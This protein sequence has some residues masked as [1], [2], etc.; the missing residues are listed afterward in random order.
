MN[1]TIEEVFPHPIEKVWAAISEPEHLAAWL[2][3]GTFSA[4]TGAHYTFDCGDGDDH[5]TKIIF[6]KV[7]D[8]QAPHRL[9]YTWQGENSGA[10][11]TVTW[12]L[13]AVEGGTLVKMV[14]EGFES[15][16]DVAATRHRAHNDGW[17]Q[18]LWTLRS[19][20]NNMI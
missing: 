18:C 1:I 11:T 13:K 16:G 12:T 9:Q 7:L 17:K 15:F 8:A 19:T 4:L 2:M 5:W 3:K 10:I 6:G 14:H 20:L